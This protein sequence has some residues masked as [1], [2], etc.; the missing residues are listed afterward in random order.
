MGIRGI[1]GKGEEGRRKKGNGK[2]REGKMEREEEGEG[3]TPP[4]LETNRCHYNL[5]YYNRSILS[6]IWQKWCEIT[7]TVP[8]TGRSRRRPS[9]IYRWPLTVVCQVRVHSSSL[10]AV[11]VPVQERGNANSGDYRYCD[12]LR[13][14]CDET[15]GTRESVIAYRVAQKSKLLPN[16]Q[17]IVL[18]RIRACR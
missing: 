15:K 11:K 8:V 2:S 3:W 5:S 6:S 10:P 12:C 18:N 16:Y 9:L 1:K 4:S 17:T 13:I 7:N 14:K